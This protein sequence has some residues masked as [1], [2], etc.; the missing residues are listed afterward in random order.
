MT[1]YG[2]QTLKKTAVDFF[3]NFGIGIMMSTLRLKLNRFMSIM[4]STGYNKNV[5][6]SI[7][8]VYMLFSQ[9]YSEIF[10][11]SVVQ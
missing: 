3:R 2:D 4:H 1:L 7:F 6:F 8:L 5:M 9:E 11:V 10:I